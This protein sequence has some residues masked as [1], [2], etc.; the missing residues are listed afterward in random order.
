MN[1][2]GTQPKK[3]CHLENYVIEILDEL[4]AWRE[5]TNITI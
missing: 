3:N 2:E 4:I 1:N 5:K